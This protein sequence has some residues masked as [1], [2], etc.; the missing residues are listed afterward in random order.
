MIQKKLNKIS[1]KECDL[2]FF[3]KLGSFIKTPK[4]IFFLKAK[5]NCI[6][7]NHAHKFCKQYFFSINHEIELLIDNGK[8]E[9]KLKLIP[10]SYAKINP[11][12]WVKVRLKK[13]QLVIVICDKN[14]SKNE[15]IRN[16][17]TFKKLAAKN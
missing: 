5:K 11:L 15:Y 9:R 13:N 3:N 12:N 10:G 2:F 16:Y 7:G 14:Y 8:S 4:R 1:G 6:R 17:K